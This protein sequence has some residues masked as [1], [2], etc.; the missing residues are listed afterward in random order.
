MRAASLDPVAG[1]AR[2][3]VGACEDDRGGVVASAKC[4]G[5]RRCVG[6]RADE[7]GE[8]PA[9]MPAGPWGKAGCGPALV[10]SPALFECVGD[11]IPA[12]T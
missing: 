5:L 2:G 11:W 1:E 8:G 3:G 7:V 10:V 12:T 9:P 6:R 4:P